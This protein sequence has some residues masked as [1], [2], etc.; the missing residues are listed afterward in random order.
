VKEPERF[1]H[2]FAVYETEAWLLSQPDIFPDAV[3][4]AFPKNVT[5]PETVDSNDHPSQLLE[6]LY[7]EKMRQEYGKTTTGPDLFNALDPDVAY[8]K[9]PRLKEML[10][11][12]LRLAKAAE[13]Q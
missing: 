4:K 2:F 10:D 3:K 1:R 6:R 7:K 9:C 11:E 5:Q 13:L 12:M 8:N